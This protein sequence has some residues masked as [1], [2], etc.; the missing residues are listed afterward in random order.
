MPALLLAF[1]SK[2][3]TGRW[4]THSISTPGARIKDYIVGELYSDQRVT[5]IYG[6]TLGIR[7][8][9]IARSVLGK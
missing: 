6:G 3:A 8:V 2:P 7:W 1:A 4:M 9:V 5:E